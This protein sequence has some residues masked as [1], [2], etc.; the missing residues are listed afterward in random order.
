MPGRDIWVTPGT[1]RDRRFQAE[2]AEDIRPMKQ[3]STSAGLEYQFRSNDVFTVHY[4]HNDLFETIE[5]IGF[6]TSTGDE[7]YIIGNPGL[8]QTSVQFSSGATPPGFADAA[9]GPQVRRARNRLQ[10]SIRQQL[11][12]QRE[13]HPEPP[14]WQ[15]LRSRGV[16]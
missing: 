15:L 1:C 11:V 12:L 3:S 8:G 5:D 4:I 6:L 7:G 9:R 14:V 2:I 10:P 13:L 16:R